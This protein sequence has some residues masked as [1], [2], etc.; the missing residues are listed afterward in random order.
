HFHADR[1]GEI[2]HRFDIAKALVL[3]EEGDRVSVSTATEAVIELLGR[4]DGKRG[5]LLGVERAAGRVV[6]SA[7]LQRD[8]AL[9]HFDD[10]DAMEQFLLEGIRYHRRN[11]LR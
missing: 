5:R 7:L 4:A 10:V 11:A 2:P 9:D 1:F 8:V 3:D 6:R